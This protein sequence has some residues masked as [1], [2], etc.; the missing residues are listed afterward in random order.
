RQRHRTDSPPRRSSDLLDD[1]RETEE[2]RQATARLRELVVATLQDVRRL[3]LELRP[4]ALDDF[5]LVAAVEHLATTFGEKSGM[6][7][8]ARRSEEPTSEL[9]SQSKIV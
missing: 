4:S 2:S 3:A 1:T 5:G 6:K 8:V 9:Q 7:V